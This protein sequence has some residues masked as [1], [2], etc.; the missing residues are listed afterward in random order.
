MAKILVLGGAHIYRRGRLEGPFHE[1]SSHPGTWA[2]EAGGG[3][4]NAARNL[5]RFGHQ[6]TLISPRGG[7]A[8]GEFVGKTALASG[9]IDRPFTFL[10][11]RTPSYTA[12]LKSDGNLIA[13]LADMDL[14]RLFSPRRLRMRAVR[15]AFASC[16]SILCDANLP[17]ETLT[18][19]AHMAH[20][21][22][23]HV[24]AIGISPAKVTRLT[25]AL[26]QLDMLFI[27]AAEARALTGESDI[28]AAIK[29]LQASGLKA[30][31]ITNGGS[32][33]HAFSH[34]GRLVY[35]PPEL[36]DVKDVTGAGDAFAAATLSATLNG[37]DLSEAIRDGVASA[38]ITL[39][40][41]NAFTPT[42]SLD[43]LRST[44]D[45]LSMP[46]LQ[47]FLTSQP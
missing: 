41:P 5:A 18:A 28:E 21:S 10:D 12:M 43:L 4:F 44:S 47:P 6:V 11:R 27:N 31:S 26:A 35:Q 22:Q 46:H 34:I 42:M 29:V 32:A 7:D 33:L 36:R 16:D 37:H 20:D 19:I 15:D 38:L 17:A 45:T 25:H 39:A 23:K 2:E 8:A 1:G 40:S 9:I 30:A 13:G 14:Y 3:A 24:S